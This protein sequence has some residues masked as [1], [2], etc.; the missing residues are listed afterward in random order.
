MAIA[1]KRF[2]KFYPVEEETAISILGAD[3]RRDA[4]VNVEEFV[5][6]LDRLFEIIETERN[7]G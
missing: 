1:P 2:A 4:Y 3:R 5:S 7:A 6:S